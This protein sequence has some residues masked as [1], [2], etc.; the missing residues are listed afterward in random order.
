MI[1]LTTI[2]GRVFLDRTLDINALRCSRD[3]VSVTNR[4]A[5]SD[6]RCLPM[7]GV[8]CQKLLHRSTTLRIP[9]IQTRHTPI[10]LNHRLGA[11]LGAEL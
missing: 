9:T 4:L 6:L 7:A 3:N 8:I 1:D 5:Y 10:H 11:A 2:S